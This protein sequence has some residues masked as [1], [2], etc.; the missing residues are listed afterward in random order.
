MSKH[1]EC[2]IINKKSGDKEVSSPSKIAMEKQTV[3]TLV[4]NLSSIQN[5]K[6]ILIEFRQFFIRAI[7][8]MDIEELE[9]GSLKF[10]EVIKETQLSHLK[11]WFL[12]LDQ[13]TKLFKINEIETRLQQ[14]IRVIDK[15]LETL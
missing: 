12:E 4:E 7:E 2:E 3:F 9:R 15:A 11:N 13:E 14:A 8:I 1:L 6:Q 5:Q 10:Q